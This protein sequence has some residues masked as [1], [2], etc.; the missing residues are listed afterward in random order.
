MKGSLKSEIPGLKEEIL[1]FENLF[2][3]YYPRLK[4]YATWFLKDA[5]E[6]EDV[7]QDVFYR[8]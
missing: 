5:D 7:V 3:R 4:N 2:R 8:L 1:S 6:A